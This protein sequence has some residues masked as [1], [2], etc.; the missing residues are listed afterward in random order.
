MAKKRSSKLHK[1]LK[2]L[3]RNSAKESVSKSKENKTENKAKSDSEQTDSAGEIEILSKQEVLYLKRDITKTIIATLAIAVV[4]IVLW[5]NLSNPAISNFI[6]STSKS[7]G[8]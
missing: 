1:H 7:F 8:F 5:L 4:I 6:D 3:Y 2:R